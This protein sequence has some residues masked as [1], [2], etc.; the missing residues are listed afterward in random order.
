MLKVMAP[1]SMS[2]QQLYMEKRPPV[3]LNKVFVIWIKLS[4]QLFS[5]AWRKRKKS[6]DNYETRN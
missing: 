1:Y 6:A 4:L 5:D 3:M 2:V